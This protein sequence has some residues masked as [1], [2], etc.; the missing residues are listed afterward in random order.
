[1]IHKLILQG[2]AFP[3]D[4]K[5]LYSSKIFEG[6]PLLLVLKTIHKH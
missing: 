5:I 3:F 4:S 1:M 2:F 6:I